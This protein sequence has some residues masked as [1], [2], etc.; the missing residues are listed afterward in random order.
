MAPVIECSGNCSLMI[1]GETAAQKLQLYDC[2]RFVFVII[3]L[4]AQRYASAAYAMAMCPSVRLSVC[5]SQVVFY[6]NG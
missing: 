6:Q 5:P 2:R 4:N 1:Y 3:F